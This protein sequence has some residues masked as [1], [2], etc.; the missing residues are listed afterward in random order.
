VIEGIRL[1]AVALCLALGMCSITNNAQAQT[2]DAANKRAVPGEVTRFFHDY[3]AAVEAGDPDKILALVDA[4]FVIKW[5]IGDPITNR[6]RLRAALAKLQES[7]RQTVE[8]EVVEARIEGEWAWARVNEIATH[9]PKDGS[10]PRILEGS[11]L[12][13]L[14]KVGGRWLLHRDYG[15]LNQMPEALR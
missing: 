2:P 11:H 4:D 12:A 3:F 13:I 1:T 6:E 9:V 15:S 8:W 7:V 14:R 10:N 5:P